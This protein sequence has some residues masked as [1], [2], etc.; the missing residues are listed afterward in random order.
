MPSMR[1]RPALARSAA[2]MVVV[3]VSTFAWSIELPAELDRDRNRLADDLEAY[4]AGLA[5]TEAAAEPVPVVVLLGAPARTADT[6]LVADLGGEVRYVFRA[7]ADGFTATVP[8]NRIGDLAAALGDRL[9][10]IGR[11]HPVEAHLDVAVQQLGVRPYAWDLGYAGGATTAIAILDTGIDDSHTDVSSR[12]TAWTDTTDHGY[13]NP[14]DIGG[15]GS[16]VTSIALGTGGRYPSPIANMSVR[17]SFSGTLPVTDNRGW[18]DNM[19][20]GGTGIGALQLSLHWSGGGSTYLG[21]RTPSWQWM[22]GQTSS[23]VPNTLNYIISTTGIYRPYVGNTTDADGAPYVLDE[24]AKYAPPLDGYALFR[25]IAPSATAVGVKVLGDD[26]HSDGT[27]V[28]EGLDWIV[29][30]RDE[31]SIRVANMSLGGSDGEIDPILDGFAAA[32]VEA[33]IV[34]VCSA[35]NDFSFFT[36]PSPGNTPKVITVGAI[37]DGDGMTNYSSN[38]AFGQ[39]KPDVVAPGGSTTGGTKIVAADSNDLDAGGLMPDLTANDYTAL[40]GTS[41][42]APM[43]S[44]LAALLIDAQERA[45]DPWGSTE[46]EALAIKALILMT[47]TETGQVGEPWWNGG[48]EP[49]TPCGNDPTLERGGRDPV[50]GFGRVNGDAA[51]EAVIRPCDLLAP[52]AVA[53]G[54][55]PSERKARACFLDAPAGGLYDLTLTVPPGLDADLYLYSAVSDGLGVPVILASSTG[56]SDADETVTGW[57][58]TSP[59]RVIVV[60]KR[61]SG[62]GTATLAVTASDGALFADDFESGGTGAWSNA[63]P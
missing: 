17:T 40:K 41:M 9:E 10:L 49:T 27:S 50:E 35:G 42:A 3:L 32:A 62:D 4:V 22:T 44:G 11:G 14:T 23:T 63:V 25:R 24:V 20:V 58:P 55:A 39:G 38:G 21:G 45:G 36:I 5:P 12:V 28:E 56:A 59:Q 60:V 31:H 48:D 8:A 18:Y 26:G 16:H 30:H 37:N 13:A 2:L 46:A 54:S 52:D 51:L 33:G 15:H 1:H 7:L 19:T 34:V 53:F 29:S 6:G 61:V 43:V 47:A 57:R